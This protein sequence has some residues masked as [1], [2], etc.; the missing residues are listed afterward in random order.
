MA[1]GALVALAGCGGHETAHRA[2]ASTTGIRWGQLRRAVRGS[3]A[4]PSDAAYDRV[5]LTQNPRYDDE[6]PL[7]VLSAASATD[8]ATA[9]RFA[10]DHGVPIALRSGGHSYPGWSGGGSPRALVI[11]VRPMHRVVLDGTRATIGAGAALAHVYDGVS[12][13]GRAIAAGS[14]PTVG[15]AGL[16]LGGG[17]GVLTRA[18]GLT[19]D[20]VRQ[21]EV[22]TADGKV[23]TVGRHRDPDL[24]WALRGGG[25]GHL[26]VVTALDLRTVAAPHVSSAFLQWP[27]SAA[28]EVIAAW[29]DWAPHADAR[30]WSTLKALGGVK[31]SSG[32]PVLLVSAAWTGPASAFEGQLAGLLAHV[33]TPSVSTRASRSYRD[34]MF[35]FAGCGSIPVAQC[36][37]GPGGALT[38]ESLAA[39]SH[40]AYA[41]LSDAGIATLVDR[42]A[43]AGPL[44]E[45]GISIDALGGRVRDVAPDATA[46]VHR[47]ALA[48][49]QYTATFPPGTASQADGFVRGFR[50]AMVPHWG[51]HA[52][53]NYAD[54]RLKR[55]RKAYFGAN[56]PRLAQVRAAYDP[57]HFFTQPQD[58]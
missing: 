37:T 12:A 33:P 28:P 3:L 52:Y 34:A 29:Q 10:Q 56:A 26:G 2:A 36:T 6:R 47:A 14:C 24:F 51:N 57:H 7:A 4:L 18:Y 58:F 8:V 46:F 45:A 22:V 17:V 30:L 50:A 43:G 44:K 38:R 48:T 40:V 41:P 49:V 23:R 31:H 55:Y 1:G 11:D 35:G 27:L 53:V 13:R 15:I 32:G 25:G 19:C 21:L 9:I 20:F 5:R 54:A 39:T 16:T 42:V